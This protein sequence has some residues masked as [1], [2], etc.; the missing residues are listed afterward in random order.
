MYIHPLSDVQTKKIGTDTRI[1]QFVVILEGAS[2]GKNCNICAHSF[3][4][5]KAV[6]KDNVTIK[7]GVYIWDRITI[8]VRKRESM[9]AKKYAY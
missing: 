1:W 7:S 6:I 3:I 5:N 8:Y 2:I 4:E 9:N